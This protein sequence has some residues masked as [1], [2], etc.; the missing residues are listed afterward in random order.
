MIQLLAASTAFQVATLAA[1]I[2]SGTLP[3]P[4]GERILV[5]ADGSQVPEL[6]T[7]ITE[8]S[9]F[10]QLATRFDRVVDLAAL[11]WPRRPHQFKPRSE[12]LGMWEKLLRSHWSLGAEPL[13]LV[14]ES[15]QVNPAMAM[16]RVFHDATVTVHS[17]GLMSYGPTRNPVSP[18]IIQRLAGIAYPELVSGLEPL[19]LREARPR[20]LPMDPAHLATV[21]AALADEA[22]DPFLD[23]LAQDS[24]RCVLVLGQYLH[25]LGLIDERAELMLHERMLE[26]ARDRGAGTVVFKPHPSASPTSALRL[27][28]AARRTGLDLRVYESALGAEVVAL[29]LRPLAV[30][31]CF[32][33]ALV[34]CS[35]LF[36][37]PAYAV[38]TAGLLHDLAPFENSNRIPLTLVDAMF[39]HHVA[40]GAELQALLETTGYAMQPELLPDLHPAAE[41]YLGSHPVERGRYFKQ[42]RLHR[43]GLPNNLPPA[44][45]AP[46]PVPVPARGLRGRLGRA[47]WRG[48][49]QPATFIRRQLDR[50]GLQRAAKR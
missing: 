30:I 34:T 40:P 47:A 29:K 26:A 9:G 7:P 13:H 25:S 6:T 23:D 14:V 24:P 27:A 42:R 22:E 15:I 18:S 43:L 35:A 45:P 38:G 41:A 10:A 21:F 48:T 31:S 11:L 20:L 36:G 39:V 37:I 44:A 32:S 16:C 46:A 33:T 5:L 17:D 8:S 4:D 1:M 50:V 28:E 49:L 19:L 3:A 2:D 12:E